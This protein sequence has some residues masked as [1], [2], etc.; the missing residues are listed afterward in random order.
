MIAVLVD[1]WHVL[2]A[3]PLRTAAL[4]V[5]VSLGSAAFVLTQGL[6][7]TVSAQVGDRFDALA[8]T[9]VIVTPAATTDTTIT[10]LATFV[11]PERLAET[12]R[13]VGLVA[14]ARVGVLDEADVRVRRPPGVPLA[15]LLRTTISFVDPAMVEAAELSITG[16]PLTPVDDL[17]TRPVALVGRSVAASLGIRAPGATLQIGAHTVTV[18][19]IVQEARRASYL[20]NSILLPVRAHSLV[21]PNT[22]L[23]PSVVVRTKAGA[24]NV[25]ASSL[26]LTL[27][28]SDPTALD[29]QAPPRPETLRRVVSEDV[30]RLA[31][32]AT[33]TV[34]AAGTFAVANL[35][36]LSITA[37]IPELGMRRA[38]GAKRRDVVAMVLAESTL[39]GVLSG[40]L[41]ALVGTWALLAIAIWQRWTPVLDLPVVVFGV[42]VGC[43]GGLLGGL[44]P[45]VVAARIPPARALRA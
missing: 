20:V 3:R 44:V 17:I 34:L 32:A 5:G 10:S 19:G 12:P 42:V 30:R 11:S 43:V 16:S 35:M 27:A 23:R 1:A 41:G 45:A 24:A 6:G 28:P 38:L 8:A 36:L 7:V 15:P 25:V 37:R 31:L 22:R 29:V 4:A 9:T 13:I 39:V 14:A 40:V 21:A 2:R 26:R 18:I 33:V